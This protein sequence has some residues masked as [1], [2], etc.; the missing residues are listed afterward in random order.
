M[1]AANATFSLESG[2]QKNEA[3]ELGSVQMQIDGTMKLILRAST[4]G[5]AVLIFSRLSTPSL[6][7]DACVQLKLC[8]GVVGWQRSPFPSVG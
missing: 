8:A 5:T 1:L 7:L 3:R 2:G 6:A 4:Q